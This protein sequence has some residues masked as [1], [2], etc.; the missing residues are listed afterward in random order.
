MKWINDWPVIGEDKDGDGKGQPVLSYKKPNVGRSYP[1]QTP[2]ES[3]EFNENTLGLQ[4]Q[5]M[6]NSQATWYF[7]NPSKGYL[8]LFSYKLPDSARNLWDA[9]NVLLQKFPSDEF[10]V[11]TKI[12]FVPNPKLENEKAGLAIMGLSYANIALKSKKDGIYLVF[13]TC[14]DADKGN[15]EKETE[16]AKLNNGELYLRVEVTAGGKCNFYY[17]KDGILFTQAGE[18]FTAE[19]GRWIGAKVGIFCTRQTQIND[20]GWADFDWF[21]VEKPGTKR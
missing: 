13:S 8:R 21:R 3:D 18:E 1:I 15:A 7:M 12:N 14:K 9:P 20:S 19:V 6:A 16:M 5:W 11:T 10:M 17:S 4:W 2:Q